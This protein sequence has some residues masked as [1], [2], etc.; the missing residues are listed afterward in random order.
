MREIFI[1]AIVVALWS[2]AKT[3]DTTSS[4]TLEDSL[5][6]SV[7]ISSSVDTSALADVD[8]ESFFKLESYLTKVVTNDSTLEIVDRDCAILIYPTLEQIEEMKRTEGE[9][10]F[11]IGAD[12]ANWYQAQVIDTLDYVAIKT[13]TA[14][15]QYVRLK[16]RKR[17]WDLDIRKKNLPAWN[18]I[19]FKTTKEPQIVSMTDLTVDEVKTYFE[20]RD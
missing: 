9:E 2:C 11:Y 15:R 13:I 4:D 19:L 7:P 1:I 5:S 10:N 16:G 14:S 3:T 12:D 6:T 18:V 8:Y 20:I 17:I